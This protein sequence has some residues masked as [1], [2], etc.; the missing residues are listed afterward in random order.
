MPEITD[1]LW[2]ND[3]EIL[4]RNNRIMEIIPTHDMSLDEKLNSLMRLSILTGICLSILMTNYLYLYIPIIMS[5]VQIMVAYSNNKSVEV[6]DKEIE[7]YQNIEVRSRKV[8]SD[9]TCVKPTQDNPF[10]NAMNYDSR[11]RQPACSSY[12]DKKTQ[13]KI[14]DFF[15]NNLYKDVSD[16]YNKRHSQRQ[17][18]TMPYTT[19]P[20][21]QGGFA[22][23]L[24]GE[25]ETCKEGNGFQC[26]ANNYERLG[27]N[28]Y[29]LV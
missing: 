16:V 14:D 18:F 20:N 3:F 23:W 26:V 22:R 15:D 19:F 21:D 10:M 4:F 25:P 13:E 27:G 17:F 9:P 6:D 11:I 5:L 2:T 1:K 29:K 7:K 12:D 24:Y 8:G 28:S